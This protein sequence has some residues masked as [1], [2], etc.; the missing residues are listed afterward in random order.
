MYYF[1]RRAIRKDLFAPRRTFND[2]FPGYEN[3][4]AHYDAGRSAWADAAMTVPVEPGGSIERIQDL[5]PYARHLLPT[6]TL[7]PILVVDNG[8]PA[9]YSNYFGS[10]PHRIFRTVQSFAAPFQVVA[11]RSLGSVWSF[12]GAFFGRNTTAPQQAYL[13]DKNT[14]RFYSDSTWKLPVS[15]RRNG[16][17]SNPSSPLTNINQPFVLSLG[18][19]EPAVVSQ[20]ELLSCTASQ[21]SASYFASFYLYECVGFASTPDPTTLQEIEVY[22]MTKYGITPSS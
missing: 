12:Y 10:E 4:V 16:V 20:W 15:V 9:F 17:V 8:F 22:L 11:A 14:A 7:R 19:A 13:F 1:P 6:G 5:S 21:L 18:V 3:V 2:P